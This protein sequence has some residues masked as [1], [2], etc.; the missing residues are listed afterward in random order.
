MAKLD[1]K[2]PEEFHTKLGLVFNAAIALPLLPFVLLF[3][4]IKNNEFVGYLQEGW[5]MVILSYGLPIVSGL[6]VVKG[7]KEVEIKRAAALHLDELKAKLITYYPGM[8]KL[9][10]LVAIACFILA[11]GLWLTSSGVIIVAYVIVLFTM[12]LYR[13]T[14]KRYVMDLGLEESNKDIILN[15]K[16]FQL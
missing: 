5:P 7:F 11:A 2:T 15:Q 10:L 12:S 6:L 13:P 1:F 14:P 4:E 9:Y 3:L 16:D 8:S